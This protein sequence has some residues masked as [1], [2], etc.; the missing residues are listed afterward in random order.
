MTS[1]RIA[2]LLFACLAL[3]AYGAS[4]ADADGA[5]CLGRDGHSA[6]EGAA[7]HR[8]FVTPRDGGLWSTAGH[9]SCVDV[10]VLARDGDASRVLIPVFVTPPTFV[11]VDAVSAV[12]SRQDGRPPLPFAGF[13]SSVLR[14]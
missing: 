7:E 10:T 1:R 2:L 14:I 8:A 3:T 12:A 5:L 6:I 13:G 11:V 9:G 4:I